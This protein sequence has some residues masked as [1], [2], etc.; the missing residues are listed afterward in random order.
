[1]ILRCTEN[2]IYIVP[3]VLTQAMFESDSEEE[4]DEASGSAGVTQRSGVVDLED[5][6]KVMHVA[7]VR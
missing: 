6:G 3:L 4:H 2:C 5:L 1:M 7:K